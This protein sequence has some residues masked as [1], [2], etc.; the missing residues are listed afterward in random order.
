MSRDGSLLIKGEG[1][2][3]LEGTLFLS[4]PLMVL[5]IFDV[6]IWLIHILYLL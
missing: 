2:E 4:I 3:M 6:M 1:L 5:L